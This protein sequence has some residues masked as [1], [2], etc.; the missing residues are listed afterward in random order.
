MKVAFSKR[1]S[2]VITQAKRYQ[3]P[4]DER[5]Q[6]KGKM[7]KDWKILNKAQSNCTG[8]IVKFKSQFS[9]E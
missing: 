8:K 3:A 4:K 7:S 9:P 1:E 5:A 2:T 6:A